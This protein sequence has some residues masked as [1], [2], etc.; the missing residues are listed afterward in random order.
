MPNTSGIAAASAGPSCRECFD[1]RFRNGAHQPAHR[2]ADRDRGG[3]CGARPAAA[4]RA[5]LCGRGGRAASHA[6]MLAPCP[7][8][9]TAFMRFAIDV[10]FLDRQGYAVKIVRNLV[11]WGIPVAPRPHA[12]VELAAGSLEDVDLSV[13]DRLFLSTDTVAVPEAEQA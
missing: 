5:R 10:V 6:L 3:A 8:V 11:P 4:A 1:G 13:G 12:V 9:H 2:R 7:A